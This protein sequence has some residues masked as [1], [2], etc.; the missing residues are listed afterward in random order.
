M[1]CNKISNHLFHWAILTKKIWLQLK[2]VLTNSSQCFQ[3]YSCHTYVPQAN[4]VLECRFTLTA[5]SKCH[6]MNCSGIINIPL[7]KRIAISNA[8]VVPSLHGTLI[9]VWKILDRGRVVDVGKDFA[10]NIPGKTIRTL[11]L[12]PI[13][14]WKKYPYVL[15]PSRFPLGKT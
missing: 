9:S 11:C 13:A 1:I 15:L 4:P 14:C 3:S 5:I 7:T 2:K 12:T 10:Y 8:I 6:F